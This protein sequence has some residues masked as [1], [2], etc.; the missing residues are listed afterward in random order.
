MHTFTTLFMMYSVFSILTFIAYGVDKTA[1]IN[2]K[3]RIKESHLHLLSLAGG[4]PGAIY[5]QKHY[6]HKTQKKIFRF[7]FWVTIVLNLLFVS[8]YLV[9][10]IA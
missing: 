8:T 4:W 3:H 1:A 10:P 7:F 5:A 9:N 2:Q 6:R